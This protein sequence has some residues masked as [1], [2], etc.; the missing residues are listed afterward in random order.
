MP[1]KIVNVNGRGTREGD[2]KVFYTFYSLSLSFTHTPNYLRITYA[3]ISEKKVNHFQG[4]VWAAKG[5]K[6]RA[7]Y[8]KLLEMKKKDS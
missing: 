6:I 1:Y 3:N 7:Y 4:R 8:T 5:Q 2:S